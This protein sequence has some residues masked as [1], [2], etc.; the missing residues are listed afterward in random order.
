MIQKQFLLLSLLLIAQSCSTTSSDDN[1]Y[2]LLISKE[3]QVVQ[4]S[5]KNG[6]TP[7]SFHN[8]QSLT[9]SLMSVLIG[10]A[11]DKGFIASEA[12]T[13][14]QYFSKEYGTLAD[15]RKKKIRIIDLLNQTSGL[16]WK[17]YLE[18][19]DWLKSTDQIGYVLQ[20]KMEADPGTIYNYN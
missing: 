11:I 7:D 4:A 6:A 16:S 2:V 12:E 8:I 9:K 20:K 5:Y 13:I 18:Q 10:I 19:E 15:A 14:D 3:N 1:R 17:G